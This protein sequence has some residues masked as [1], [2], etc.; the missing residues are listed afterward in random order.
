MTIVDPIRDEKGWAFAIQG[1]WG[2][3]LINDPVNDFHF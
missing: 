3:P 2:A 1:K